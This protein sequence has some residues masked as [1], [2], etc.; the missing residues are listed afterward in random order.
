[1][2]RIERFP[3]EEIKTQISPPCQA[4]IKKEVIPPR[5]P[6]EMVDLHL[7]F[8]QLTGKV[9]LFV[10]FPLFTVKNGHLPE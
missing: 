8:Q 2:Q 7:K 3:A 1:M 9:S 6:G 10:F 4:G 5:F